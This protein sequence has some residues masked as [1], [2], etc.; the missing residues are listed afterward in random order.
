MQV[1]ERPL[2]SIFTQLT[3]GP[4]REQISE[5][6]RYTLNPLTPSSAF[7]EHEREKIKFGE[8][9]VLELL[10][11]FKEELEYVDA[12]SFDAVFTTLL[13]LLEKYLWCL[14]SATMN[15]GGELILADISL[16]DHLKT[17]SAIAACLYKFHEH[18]IETY[19]QANKYGYKLRL[20]GGEMSGIQN[21]LYKISAIGEGGVAKRLRSRSFYITALTEIIIL[22]ILDTFDLPLSCNLFSTGGKFLILVPNLKNEVV[23]VDI[24][25][26]AVERQIQAWL[27]ENFNGEIHLT[28][29]WQEDKMTGKDL[30]ITRFHNVAE[31][32][33]HNLAS[34]EKQQLKSLFQNSG[35]WQTNSFIRKIDLKNVSVESAPV[36]RLNFRSLMLT[37]EW[38]VR[39]KIWKRNFV[40]SAFLTK[41]L[42]NDW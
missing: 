4:E 15:K 22:H 14:P 5:R 33:Y 10:A 7:P 39:K 17:T 37:I 38:N 12:N 11:Q 1:Y 9:E 42:A 32:V 21:Y 6:Y 28:L 29:D 20:V 35:S 34:K 30:N 26:K 18:E 23:D 2:D 40:E 24:E 3:L 16:Y 36:F 8:K 41:K 13:S 31:R 25:M 27:W 19:S